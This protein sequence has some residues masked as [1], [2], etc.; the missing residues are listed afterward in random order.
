MADETK[1]DAGPSTGGSGW[2]L[3]GIIGAMILGALIG[4][5]KPEIGLR[6]KI[7]GE[8][9]LNAL[10]MIVV[11]LVV[12]SMITGITGLGDIRRLGSL[13][14]RTVLYYAGT[15][16]AAVVLGLVLVNVIRPGSGIPHGEEQAALTYTISGSIVTLSGHLSE[17]RYDKRYVVTL[18]DQG[19]TAPIESADATQLVVGAWTDQEGREVTPERSGAGVAVSLPMS[20]RLKGKPRAV[21]EVLEEMVR[22]LIPRNLFAAAAETKVLPLIIVSLIFGA[23]LTTMGPRGE[24]AIRLFQSLNEAV[25]RV[26][27]LIM[28]VAPLG[29]L[30][31]IAG[32]IGEAGGFAGFMPELIGLGKYFLTVVS[33]LTLHGVVTLVLI[34]VLI[35]RRRPLAYA[36]NMGAALLNA[37]CTASSSA[38][39]PLTIQGLEERSKISNRTAAFVAPLGA[40]INMDGTALYEAVAAIFI[41]QVYGI[42]LG[43]AGMVVVALTATLASIGAA[44]IPEA[45]LVTMLI[46][47]TAVQLPPEGVA[48]ILTIDWLLDRF[49]TTVN[50]WGDAVGA[51]VVETLEGPAPE[52][53]R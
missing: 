3:Y 19:C 8:L 31:L 29:I 50:V 11:P 10:M 46:V 22:G 35:G 9:F 48:L 2:L 7:I 21:G 34:L 18:R 36:R 16:A 13:G 38:T 53:P 51:A 15:T 27:H 49:R 17:T 5:L 41:A 47:L 37:F 28:A 33:G 1:N 45:G 6:L 44:G 39:L 24:P 26:V 20:E 12:L 30:G 25:M 4:G 40:T 52:P 23:V 42:E 14:R 32:R 43:L